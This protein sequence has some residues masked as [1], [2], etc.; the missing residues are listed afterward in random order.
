MTLKSSVEPLL[1]G[2]PFKRPIPMERSQDNVDLNINIL[3]S[4]PDERPPLLKSHFSCAKGVAS[5]DRYHC[6]LYY[7]FSQTVFF[8]THCN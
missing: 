8:Y 5:Q 2:H 4:I 1:R 6:S 3:I 7:L